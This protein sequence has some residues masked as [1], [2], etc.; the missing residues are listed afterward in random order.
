MTSEASDRRVAVRLGWLLA[1]FLLVFHRGHFMSSDELGSYFQTR[2][3]ARSFSLEIPGS[4]HM[5]FSGRDGRSYSHYAIG[6][7]LL[8]A[9]LD[10][11]YAEA[12][13]LHRL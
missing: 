13:L 4:V 3:I 12:R 6:Q 8:A 5:A 9:P 7:S 11:L 1:V 10:A 2:S